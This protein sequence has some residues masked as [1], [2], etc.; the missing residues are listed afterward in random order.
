[1]SQAKV[2]EGLVGAE[3]RSCGWPSWP[4]T[5]VRVDLPLGGDPVAGPRRARP[6]AAW[7]V[8]EVVA[9][10]PGPPVH[11]VFSLNCSCSLR[12]PPKTL[13]PMRAVADR[14]RLGT[15]SRW[16]ARR[17]RG[18]GR[19]PCS[20]R[21]D[22]HHR[23][24]RRSPRRSPRPVPY[25]RARWPRPPSSPVL[26]YFSRVAVCSSSRLLCHDTNP[27]GK[28]AC[29]SGTETGWLRARD[30]SGIGRDYSVRPGPRRDPAGTTQSYRTALMSASSTLVLSYQ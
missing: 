10:E 11:S 5:H 28:N 24:R 15:P 20:R 25:R 8:A 9:G 19:C 27:E 13:A 7:P 18:S 22:R 21:R 2:T 29:G 12:T 17:T 1:M 26:G 6:G 30:D 4:A 16:R 14:Q 3:R 23:D